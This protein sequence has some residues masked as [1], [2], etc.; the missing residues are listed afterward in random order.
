MVLSLQSM[1]HDQILEVVE[2][3]NPDQPLGLEPVPED[4]AEM[5][6]VLNLETPI[7][8]VEFEPMTW[9]RMCNPMSPPQ[10]AMIHG[11]NTR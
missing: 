7:D 11:T 2:D 8:E 4:E 9:E 5:D 3:E 10:M 1:L 6:Q